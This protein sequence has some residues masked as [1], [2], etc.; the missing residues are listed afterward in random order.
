MDG[1]FFDH[2]DISTHLYFNS[3]KSRK[4]G[5]I[6]GSSQYEQFINSTNFFSC[7]PEITKKQFY[8]TYQTLKYDDG[9]FYKDYW[10]RR[11]ILAIPRAI[12]TLTVTIPFNLFAAVIL[13]PIGVILITLGKIIYY[14]YSKGLFQGQIIQDIKNFFIENKDQLKT[15]G[16]DFLKIL[17]VANIRNL[18]KIYGHLYTLFEDVKGSRIVSKQQLEN[19]FLAQKRKV[20]N[21]VRLV[22]LE[23][24]L[25]TDLA[26]KMFKIFTDIYQEKFRELDEASFKV[27]TFISQYKNNPQKW[28]IYYGW[29]CTCRY[30]LERYPLS[31]EN[32]SIFLRSFLKAYNEFKQCEFYRNNPVYYI[33]SI[34]KVFDKNSDWNFGNAKS[35]AAESG[36]YFENLK[37]NKDLTDTFCKYTTSVASFYLA[38]DPQQRAALLEI[39]DFDYTLKFTNGESICSR[40]VLK[41]LFP[42]RAKEFLI[43]NADKTETLLLSIKSCEKNK[44]LSKL[45]NVIKDKILSYVVAEDENP[46]MIGHIDDLVPQ[47]RNVCK[48]TPFRNSL[49]SRI[50]LIFIKFNYG[51]EKVCASLLM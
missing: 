31:S 26:Q 11:K 5:E 37:S 17:T 41:A 25:Q 2:Y 44:K 38:L 29:I 9:T 30:F 27:E 19:L 39:F 7:V 43:K 40:D 16:L 15:F 24:Q 28:I 35:I 49:L 48:M 1:I 45:P 50:S 20:V 13:A 8:S 46:K 18:Y 3:L 23:E 21:T 34:F 14:V 22:D 33:E 51:C 12:A 10:V 47:I 6:V 42:L 36:N 32:N 4:Q